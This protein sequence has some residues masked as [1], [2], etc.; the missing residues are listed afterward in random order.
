[1]TRDA[2]QTIPVVE[3]RYSALNVSAVR[4]LR[5]LAVIQRATTLL[6]RAILVTTSYRNG[7]RLKSILSV[8]PWTFRPF[9]RRLGLEGHGRS[10]C[11]NGRLTNEG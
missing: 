5:V 6:R 9:R 4:R 8:G 11:F 1:M 3:A 10:D 7:L 2:L